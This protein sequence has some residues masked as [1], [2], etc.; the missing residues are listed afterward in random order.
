MVFLARFDQVWHFRLRI[1]YWKLK[2]LGRGGDFSCIYGWVPERL[3]YHRTVILLDCQTS[4]GEYTCS[5]R[6]LTDD[7][8]CRKTFDGSFTDSAQIYHSQFDL[9]I[10]DFGGFG[11]E[12][13]STYAA[14]RQGRPGWWQTLHRLGSPLCPKK[15]IYFN[16]P[17]SIVFI[18]VPGGRVGGSSLVFGL[19]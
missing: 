3:F 12:V 17:F 13:S 7:C 18:K 1:V 15:Y 11:L 4:S 9:Y 2:D 16:P 10:V 5:F 8:G 19:F 6:K 14:T